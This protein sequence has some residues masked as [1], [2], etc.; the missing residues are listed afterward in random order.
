MKI[1]AKTKICMVIGD[2]I[3]HSLSPQIHNAGYEEMGIDNDY[4]YVACKVKIQDIAD[5]IK[6]VRAMQ[7]RGVSCTIPHKIEV[8]KYLDKVDEVAKKIG[9][10][11]TIVN[12]HGVLKGYNT[13][14]VGVVLAL[15]KITS[16]KGKKVAIIG[17]GGAARAAAYGV[18]QRGSKLTIF[19]RTFEKAEKLAKEFNGEARSFDDIKEIK[20]MDVIFNAT[21]VGLHPKE[22]ETPIPKELITNNHIVFDAIYV[23]YE[24]RL[25]KEAKQQGAIIV[26]GAEMFLQQAVA[27]FKLYTG[28]EAPENVMRRVLLHHL[29]IKEK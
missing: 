23:P 9:A 4:V 8:I 27:Q 3:E 2:P 22:N 5:F 18:I 26:H 28:Y 21:P 1:S 10:V 24:T 17:A 29:G 6:G 12:D 25:L 15:E 13:D 19:N 16:L 11:N 20:N 7:I 14:W